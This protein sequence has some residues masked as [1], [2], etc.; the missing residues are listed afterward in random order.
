MIDI[1]GLVNQAK[2]LHEA[3]RLDAAEPVYLAV[4]RMDDSHAEAHH[5]LG[6]L[7]LELGNHAE[8]LEHLKQ[9]VEIDFKEPRYWEGWA[10]GQLIAHSPQAALE[11][12]LHAQKIGAGSAGLDSL[13]SHIEN[14]LQTINNDASCQETIKAHDHSEGLN[15]KKTSVAKTKTPEGKKTSKK[16][17]KEKKRLE[18]LFKTRKWEKMDSLARE[19]IKYYPDDF[20]AYKMLGTILCYKKNYQESLPYLTRAIEL[21]PDVGTYNTLGL[22]FQNLNRIVDAFQAYARALEIDPENPSF[23]T[24][25]GLALVFDVMG[26]FEKAYDYYQKALAIKPDSPV[27]HNNLGA[28]LKGAKK[29]DEALF[30]LDQ[31]LKYDPLH[32][33]AHSNKA[34]LLK[35][36]GRIDEANSGTLIAISAEK[37]TVQARSYFSNYLFTLNY[38]PDKAAK[39]IFDEYCKFDFRYGQAPTSQ[40]VVYN[41][42][43]N[44]GRRLRIGYVSPDFRAHSMS[45]FLEPL[46]DNHDKSTVEIIA[47]S[48][49]MREDSVTARYRSYV[50]HWV[51]TRGLTDDEMAEKI[52][53]DQVDILVDLAGHTAA[54]RLGVFAKRPAPV[55]ISYWIGYGYTSGLKS[56]DYF[57]CDDV[58]V[59]SGFEPLFSEKPWKLS[60]P[61]VAYRPSPK[62]GDVNPLPALSRDYLVFGCLSRGIR[63]NH[64]VVR[65]WSEILRQLPTSRLFINSGSFASSD[66]CADLERR[67]AQHG[68]EA[69]RLDIGYSSPPWDILRDIDIMLDCFPHNS[70]TTLVESLYMG[71]PYITLAS[72]PSVGRIGSVYLNG[73]GRQEWVAQSEQ[74][75]IERALALA[76]DLDQLSKIRASLRSELLSSPLCDEVGLVR[77]VEEAYR[78]M[79]NI[80]CRSQAG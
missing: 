78:A 54:N 10:T 37:N 29:F 67:F 63:I 20:Y 30:H 43:A 39:E 2:A 41:N 76:S 19:I 31:S 23:Y 57:L 47:Y 79:W 34:S 9:A 38:H 68:I 50:D 24:Y 21:N 52:R 6:A 60:A 40:A 13:K 62:A 61:S 7:L 46:L 49:W 18:V 11:I 36:Y 64:H 15:N 42:S 71:V 28:L 73:I 1:E 75:Y 25:N 77:R 55:S 26:S 3:G 66:L 16:L 12:V 48:D 8:G 56:I 74:D 65:V 14:I 58:I 51:S 44:S 45:Y 70:G 80:W 5:A 59:P 4:L 53:S 27:A 22:S 35:E 32:T 33:S 72:R 69:E 17:E